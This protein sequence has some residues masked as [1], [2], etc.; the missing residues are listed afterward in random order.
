MTKGKK[1]MT[2]KSYTY[3]CQCGAIRAQLSCDFERRRT[4]IS[5]PGYYEE[6]KGRL[7]LPDFIKLLKKH[8]PDLLSRGT[9]SFIFYYEGRGYKLIAEGKQLGAMRT[10]LVL[11]DACTSKPFNQEVVPIPFNKTEKIQQAIELATQH[12]LHL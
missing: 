6:V 12:M 4:L 7:L 9:F 2:F 1:V 5:M 8:C 3:Y 10:M 11:S